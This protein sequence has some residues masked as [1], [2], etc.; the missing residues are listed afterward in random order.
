MKIISKH[1]DYYDG[2]LA[3]FG[4]DETRVYD[5]RTTNVIPVE[6]R[7]VGKPYFSSSEYYCDSFLFYIC[8]FKKTVLHYKGNFYFSEKEVT[9]E[10]KIRTYQDFKLDGEKTNLNLFY[11]TP[12]LLDNNYRKFSIPILSDFNFSQYIP[13]KEMYQ[14]I[15]DYLGFLKDNPII[16]NNQKDVEKIVS[17]GFDKKNSF[18]PK[19]K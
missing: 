5:R 12:I 1:F 4:R 2:C 16:K 8:G 14:K 17:H 7:A 15:Y 18:R 3:Y 9:K 10:I 6:N 19:I 11:R 13:A